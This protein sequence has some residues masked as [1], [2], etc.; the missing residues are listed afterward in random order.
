MIHLEPTSEV[1]AMAHTAFPSYKG[2][3]FKLDNSGHAVNLTSHWD[4]GSRDQF[5]ILQLGSGQTKAVPQNGTMF[6]R[7]H[8]DDA[9]VPAGFVIVEHSVFCGKDLGITFHVDPESAL[10]FLPLPTD[11]SDDERLVLAVT[12]ALKASYDGRK[13]RQ[14]EARRKGMSAETFDATK[15]ALIAKKLLNKAG[16]ITTAGRNAAGSIY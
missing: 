6:D 9:V 12:C 2:R 10:A 15:S 8:V 3:K 5:V 14:D 1:K 16:A 4:G 13:P 11:L 7:V